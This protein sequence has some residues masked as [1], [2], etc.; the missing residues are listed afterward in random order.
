[1]ARA[2]KRPLTQA[3]FLRLMSMMTQQRIICNGLAQRDFEEVWPE[4]ERGA[5]PTDHRL[6]SL[7]TPK[8]A[9]LRELVQ[10]LALEEGR[11]VVVFSQ[12][13]RMLHL[14]RWA[15]SDLL[16]QEGLKAVYFTGDESL[17]R[18]AR[19]VVEFHDDPQVRLFFAT[20][21]GGVG[22][23]LQRAASALV[24]LDL[25]WNPA[26]LEQRN[27]R[28]HRFGQEEPVEL[29]A[30]VAA[31]GIEARIAGVV[32]DKKALFD[33]L[34]DGSTDAV[35]F[36]RGSSFLSTLKQLV[37]AEAKPDLP[38][39]GASVSSEAEALEQFDV[40]EVAAP[41]VEAEV[42][43]TASVASRAEPKAPALVAPTT[44]IVPGIEVRR[45]EDGRLILEAQPEAA[46]TFAAMLE[47][48]AALMRQVSAA[49]G[50][51]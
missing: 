29:Y 22:L 18:R 31:S 9:E 12:W 28:L 49:Q 41:A 7:F 13:K 37:P 17:Q 14:A 21:A 36:E 24:H 10:R 48:V 3:E 32:G 5:K 11:K 2:S 42:V 47:S 16:E 20:D 34:F 6:A 43:D 40:V 33:G 30:I 38:E 8:L 26:V 44:G 46:A 4:L 23:N 25:P 15:V 39:T 19:N 50:P 45:T 51:K 1:M 27:G 35:A